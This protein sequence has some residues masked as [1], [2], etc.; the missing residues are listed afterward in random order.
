MA[1]EIPSP[2]D[3]R[4]DANWPAIAFLLQEPEA[5][6]RERDAMRQFHPTVFGHFS[7]KFATSSHIDSSKFLALGATCAY[8]VLGIIYK[9][10]LRNCIILEDQLMTHKNMPS[11]FMVASHIHPDGTKERLI[12]IAVEAIQDKNPLLGTF[13]KKALQ[14]VEFV[15]E[16]NEFGYGPETAFIT[17][18]YEI[19]DIF[20]KELLEANN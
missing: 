8:G 10:K 14:E 9:E 7:E 12:Q 2:I 11:P 17:G 5:Q 4:I 19:A 15:G 18:I 13:A 3:P 16:R 6:S 1:Q 20:P